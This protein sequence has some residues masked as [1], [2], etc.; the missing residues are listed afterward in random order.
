MSNGLQAARL[1]LAD[2]DGFSEPER[3]A[4]LTLLRIGRGQA[5]ADQPPPAVPLPFLADRQ[6]T[7]SEFD[8][9]HAF[10]TARDTFPSGWEGL[11]VIPSSGAPTAVRVAYRQRK[12]NLLLEWLGMLTWRTSELGRYTRQGVRVRIVRQED[13][14]RC[15]V[16]ESLTPHEVSYGSDLLPPLHPGCRCVLMT[17]ATVAPGEGAGT[18]GR[19]HSR[20]AS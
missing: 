7:W 1:A 18:R 9:W 17:V 14:G 3:E 13:G 15:P 11:H 16:C 4:I 19:H 12:L 8:R 20:A 5:R 2:I 10:F 6:F